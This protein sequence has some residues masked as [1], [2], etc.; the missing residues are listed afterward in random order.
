MEEFIAEIKLLENYSI[1][2]KKTLEEFQFKIS[3]LENQLRKS[4][5]FIIKFH[6]QLFLR[7]D[8]NRTTS[9]TQRKAIESL[10]STR[11]SKSKRRA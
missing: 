4:N 11:T 8:I 1:D 9:Q 10:L 7:N 3:D 6:L 2:N 5:P